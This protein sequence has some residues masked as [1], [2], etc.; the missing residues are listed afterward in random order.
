ML[1]SLRAFQFS[2]VF[3]W[4]QVIDAHTHSFA[5]AANVPADA[6]G[7]SAEIARQLVM[8]ARDKTYATAANTMLKEFNKRPQ[9]PLKERPSPPPP[10]KAAKKKTPAATSEKVEPAWIVSLRSAA[11][12]WAKN[13]TAEITVSQQASIRAVMEGVLAEMDQSSPEMVRRACVG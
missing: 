4:F 7:F 11:A 3:L 9:K 5:A 13:P 6:A 10:N 12:K 8:R 2:A 1:L